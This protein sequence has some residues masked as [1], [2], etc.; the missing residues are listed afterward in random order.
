[1][2]TVNDRNRFSVDRDDPGFSMWSTH[3][4][5]DAG[6]W[7]VFL[8]GSEIDQVV[9]ADVDEG[10]VIV[11]VRDQDGQLKLDATRRAVERQRL[12]GDVTVRIIDD[13]GNI[14]RE[15]TK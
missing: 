3:G 2:T 1:M 6:K 5:F 8:D 10:F 4:G 15:W 11:N 12:E 13:Q 9:T 14:V 7:T